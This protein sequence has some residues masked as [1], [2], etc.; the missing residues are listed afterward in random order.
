MNNASEDD[1]EAVY[2]QGRLPSRT[3][4]SKAFAITRGKPDDIGKDARFVYK[5]I[6]Q[7]EVDEPMLVLDEWVIRRSPGG[8]TQVK[9]LVMGEPGNI[10]RIWIQQVPG[11]GFGGQVSTKLAL[12]G[13][14]AR[15]LAEL[16]RL[17][18]SVPLEGGQSARLDESVLADILADP[19][20]VGRLYQR[21]T[22]RFRKLIHD[23]ESAQDVVA[24]RARRKQL[25]RFRR[26][27]DDEDYFDAA[28][29]AVPG[30]SAEKVWQLMFEAN[31]WMLGVSLGGQL[32]LSWDPSK[33]EKAV[34]GRSIHGVGKR[35]DAL[36]KTAGRVSSMVFAEVKTHRTDLLNGKAYRPGC[37][38]ASEELSGAIA[39]AQGTVHRAVTEIG[40]MLRSTDADGFDTTS[41]MTY[42]IRPR[43]FVIIGSTAQLTNEVGG[44]HRERIASFELMRRQLQEPEIVTFDEVLARAEWFV[45]I[46]SPDNDEDLDFDR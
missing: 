16:F 43:S 23:D 29:K 11:I 5:V 26:L 28:R 36:M 24:V 44:H 35:T 4:L 7:E 42:L 15:R 19:G 3:Y 2:A 46:E 45:E 33:L 32:L 38:S 27:L 30:E 13:D 8:R 34:T 25:D 31:P 17:V 40:E 6:D 1:D 22:T 10:E 18:E 41:E 9:F 21:N 14:D 37:W 20:A 12:E 39:Q